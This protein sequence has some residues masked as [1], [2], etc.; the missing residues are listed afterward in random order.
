MTKFTIYAD[1]QASLLNG[2]HTRAR[3]GDV[4]EMARAECEGAR[5]IGRMYEIVPEQ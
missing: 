5:R 1:S 2:P 3:G 4:G